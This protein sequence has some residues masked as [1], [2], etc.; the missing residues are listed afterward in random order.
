MGL[1]KTLQQSWTF[2][3]L[4]FSLVVFGLWQNAQP[5]KLLSSPPT[6]MP[7]AIVAAGEPIQPLPVPSQL[8]AR[9][10]KLGQ[11]LFHSRQ[12]SRT[13]TISCA[14]C[15]NLNLGGT[16]RLPRSVGIEG[17][18]GEFNAPTV[19]N[20]GFNFR[21]F[22]D[23]R[24]KT[25]KDQIDWP[26]RSEKEMDSSWPEIIGKLKRSPDYIAAFQA[27][28]ADGIT[29][30]NIKEAI[31]TFERSLVT[32]NSRFDRYLRGDRKALTPEEQEGYRRFKAYG[33]AACH[34][35]VN[36]GGNMFQ[37][38][39]IFGNYFQDRGTETVADRGRY[40][41]TGKE[42][43]RGLFKVPSL[44]N[45]ELTSPYFH[46]GSVETLAEAVQ[47]MGQ[48]QLGRQL[49]TEDID[50]IVQFLTTLTGELP[51]TAKRFAQ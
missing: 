47:V 48:Y 41:V 14:S 19:F 3:F 43:D 30:N 4:L 12:F 29:S 49:S 24:A 38:F 40:N 27:L 9:K 18:T 5:D 21:Q 45:V 2:L 28:Y 50:A 6:E 39:G 34:Q 10:I 42:R 16:D 15:H 13:N 22:W 1:K 8:D 35:G 23:G 51:A 11:D 46:D 36:V 7:T 37:G 32:P 44:R 31:A 26:V 17:K 33:C 25:L 20:S